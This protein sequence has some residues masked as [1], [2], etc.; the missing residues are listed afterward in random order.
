MDSVIPIIDTHLHLVYK[1]RFAYPWL[2]GAPHIDRQWTA[3]SYFAAAVPLGIEKALHMEVDA[4]EADMLAETAFMQTVHPRV[5]GATA[6]IGAFEY[7]PTSPAGSDPLAVPAL[8]GWATTLLFGF[9]AWIGARNAASRD[10]KRTSH[11]RC[12][13]GSRSS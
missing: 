13:V 6:D 8:T 11:A 4:A 10:R 7:R 1:D 2:S 9:L 3:E 5:V 12:D